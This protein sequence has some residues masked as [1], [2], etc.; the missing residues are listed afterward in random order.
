M[1]FT[2][3]LSL[4]FITLFGTVKFLLKFSGLMCLTRRM[5]LI[6]LDKIYREVLL[7]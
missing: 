3:I 5:V 2:H 7:A 4:L 6:I 1:I